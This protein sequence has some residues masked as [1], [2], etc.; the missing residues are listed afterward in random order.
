MECK[1]AAFG[2]CMVSARGEGAVAL[3]RR[4]GSTT[5][6]RLTAYERARK[7]HQLRTGV[8]TRT[9]RIEWIA[10]ELTCGLCKKTIQNAMVIRV[11]TSFMFFSTATWHALSPYPK[12]AK[13]I[14][15]FLEIGEEGGLEG[16]NV[17]F[18]AYAKW[19]LSPY[20]LMSALESVE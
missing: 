20:F 4:G 5:H 11:F 14:E 13:F 17:C 6:M 12:I 15:R 10:S 2:I 3:F 18:V 8:D 1:Q 19:I 7:P 9:V 16:R